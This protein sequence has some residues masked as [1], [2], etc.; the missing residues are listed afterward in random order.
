MVRYADSVQG[1][2]VLATVTIIFDFSSVPHGVAYDNAACENKCF[3]DVTAAVI[4]V[5]K[6]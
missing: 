2:L 6:S 1:V 3:D 4:T 5:N